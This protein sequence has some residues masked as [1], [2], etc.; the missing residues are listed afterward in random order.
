MNL[1]FLETNFIQHPPEFYSKSSN[2]SVFWGLIRKVSR[3][4]RTSWLWKLKAHN[5]LRSCTA[6]CKR[7]TTRALFSICTSIETYCL[8][9]QAGFTVL[10]LSRLPELPAHTLFKTLAH[11][12]QVTPC[13]NL[14][15][16]HGEGKE[17]EAAFKVS[18]FIQL[19]GKF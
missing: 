1:L 3:G 14:H 7:K 12:K 9:L 19:Y 5:H 18:I 2:W 16:P 15:E 6:P 10:S 8:P 4:P 11:I 13:G 17:N